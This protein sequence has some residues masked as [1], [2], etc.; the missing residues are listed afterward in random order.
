MDVSILPNQPL[1]H[2]SALRDVTQSE[3]LLELQHLAALLPSQQNLLLLH[4][5][6]LQTQRNGAASP[7]T[8]P[9]TVPAQ[10]F[11]TQQSETDVSMNEPTAH[12]KREKKKKHRPACAARVPSVSSCKAPGAIHHCLSLLNASALVFSTYCRK[13]KGSPDHT[14]LLI[15]FRKK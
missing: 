2:Q 7:G 5:F 15:S 12:P 4:P 11:V 9:H 8:N 3:A 14:T 10:W 13:L 1:T 6:Q